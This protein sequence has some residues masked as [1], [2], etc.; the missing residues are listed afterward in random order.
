MSIRGE[1]RPW[2]CHGLRKRERGQKEFGD[3]RASA[4]TISF[5]D[6]WVVGVDVASISSAG[7]LVHLGPLL[8]MIRDE[9]L[10]LIEK[11]GLVLDLLRENGVQVDR[12]GETTAQENRGGPTP[13]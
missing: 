10:E 4:L 12:L 7:I 3:G 13:L 5:D 9:L 11:E 1:A 8:A 6:D 2:T